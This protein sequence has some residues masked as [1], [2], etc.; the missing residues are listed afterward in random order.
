MNKAALHGPMVWLVAVD[1]FLWMLVISVITFRVI[2]ND[3]RRM[4]SASH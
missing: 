1:F 4:R 3:E 2:A